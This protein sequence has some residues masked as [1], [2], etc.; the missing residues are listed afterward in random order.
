[1]R[2]DRTFVIKLRQVIRIE[3]LAGSR[4]QGDMSIVKTRY[5]LAN[6]SGPKDKVNTHT[7]R[8]QKVC[9]D[10]DR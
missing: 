5:R 4:D 8:Y 10:K 6:I 3:E 9:C 1:M 2:V 7:H